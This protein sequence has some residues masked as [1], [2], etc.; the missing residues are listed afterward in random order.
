ME[1]LSPNPLSTPGSKDQE[2]C[3]ENKH[4]KKGRQEKSDISISHF[5]S[6]SP[7][8]TLSNSH[9][10]AESKKL[11]DLLIVLKLFPHLDERYFG[12]KKS[13]VL[14]RGPPG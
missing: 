4:S 3:S 6:F 1:N 9:R 12:G 7:N 10:R 14:P 13:V 5:S 8:K 11:Y 2:I